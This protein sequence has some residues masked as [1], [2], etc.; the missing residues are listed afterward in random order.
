MPTERHCVVKF[1]ITIG[2]A[3]ASYQFPISGIPMMQLLSYLFSIPSTSITVGKLF[4]KRLH[5]LLKRNEYPPINF[6]VSRV[7]DISTIS[8]K[9]KKITPNYTAV[10]S[11]VL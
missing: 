2:R 3:R 10:F 9:G 8:T 11:L 7:I 6:D 1:Q 4:F 5:A